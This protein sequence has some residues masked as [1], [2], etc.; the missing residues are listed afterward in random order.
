MLYV[1]TR[2]RLVFLPNHEQKHTGLRIFWLEFLLS[3][4]PFPYPFCYVSCSLLVVEVLGTIF[5]SD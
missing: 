4:P 3:W 2:S 1:F 5:S